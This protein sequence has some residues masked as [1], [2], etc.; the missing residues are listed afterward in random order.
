MP[1]RGLPGT[2]EGVGKTAYGRDWGQWGQEQD[3]GPCRFMVPEQD[4]TVR[5]KDRL[6]QKLK[7]TERKKGTAKGFSPLLASSPG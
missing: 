3:P 6:H 5:K 1:G 2:L 7:E 4:R